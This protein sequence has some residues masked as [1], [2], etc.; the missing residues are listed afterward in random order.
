MPHQGAADI[1]WNTGSGCSVLKAI[2]EGVEYAS[3]VVHD[4]LVDVSIH[5]SREHMRLISLA[6]SPERRK[7]W[8]VVRSTCP[9]REEVLDKAQSLNFTMQWQRSVTVRAVSLGGEAD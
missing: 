6:P 2:S 4:V 5:P 1:L 9:L 8:F 3:S 7:Q